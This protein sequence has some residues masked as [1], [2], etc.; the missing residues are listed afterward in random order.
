VRW[1]FH[2]D[3]DKCCRLFSSAGSQTYIERLRAGCGRGW[4][5]SESFRIQNRPPAFFGGAFVLPVTVA[6]TTKQSEWG[7]N[8]KTQSYLNLGLHN[9]LCLLL[10]LFVLTA[11]FPST[12]PHTAYTASL[13][14]P[15]P[16]IM[17]FSALPVVALLATTTTTAATTVPFYVCHDQD[18]RP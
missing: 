16:A 6:P 4:D 7:D 15:D 18:V 17:H 13:R 5:D 1:E 3:E 2:G 14:L 8:N 10:L 12:T 9:C 11:P